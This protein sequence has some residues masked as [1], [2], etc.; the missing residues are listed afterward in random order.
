MINRD[1]TH[2]TSLVLS[3]MYKSFYPS[4]ITALS[5][6]RGLD[7]SRMS[8]A[9]LWRTSQD[10]RVIVK[11]FDKW[12]STGG[13]NG[14]LLQYSCQENPV[15][16]MKRQKIWHQKMSPWGQKVSRGQILV[17]S[18]R[19]NHGESRG[20]II[21]GEYATGESRGQKLIAPERINQLGQSGND[22]QLWICL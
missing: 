21:W 18:E 11:S 19:I 20:Q 2:S 8:W 15:N 5:L 7:N 4:R 6:A 22:N 13:G 1:Q 12:W 16:S 9:M 3:G 10:G 17:A 14:K